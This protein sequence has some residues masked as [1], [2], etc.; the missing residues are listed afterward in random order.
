MEEEAMLWEQPRKKEG[1]S[2]ETKQNAYKHNK[3]SDKLQQKLEGMPQQPHY[4]MWSWLPKEPDN[5]ETP[6]RTQH[7]GAWEN[8]DFF[9][10]PMEEPRQQPG[11]MGM[12]ESSDEERP[13]RRTQPRQQQP[14]EPGN[15]KQGPDP[16][17][18]DVDMS[19]EEDRRSPDDYEE[20]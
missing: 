11:Y 2:H 10:V 5:P 7:G 12:N 13:P 15:K 20:I 6:A 19:E 14:P 16:N 1:K 4:S 17:L 3:M 18:F 8:Q 9:K